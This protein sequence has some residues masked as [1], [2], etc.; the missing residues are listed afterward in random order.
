M[1]RQSF[2]SI[3]DDAANRF[4]ILLGIELVIYLVDAADV[5]GGHLLAQRHGAVAFGAGRKL[6]IV[7]TML[8]TKHDPR[9]GMITLDRGP[10]PPT[11][12][13]EWMREQKFGL[14]WPAATRHG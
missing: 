12:S 7:W 14:G 3:V 1:I 8:A 9:R 4:A 11:K 2:R 5:E 13:A 6:E 10:S